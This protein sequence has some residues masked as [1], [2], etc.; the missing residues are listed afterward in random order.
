M[1][2]TPEEL[3]KYFTTEQLEGAIKLIEGEEAIKSKL[4]LSKIPDDVLDMTIEI[5]EKELEE[6]Q[7]GIKTN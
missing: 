1:P 5:K 2:L 3:A 4:D 7:N 6:N